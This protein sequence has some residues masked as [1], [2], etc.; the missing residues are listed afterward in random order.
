[1]AAPDVWVS[2]C[3]QLIKKRQRPAPRGLGRP[4]TGH[5][6]LEGKTH[7]GELWDA[8]LSSVAPAAAAEGRARG[9]GMRRMLRSRAAGNAGAGKAG[10]LQAGPFHIFLWVPRAA[11]PL[12]GPLSC[13]PPTP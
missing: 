8:C 12:L 10:K 4:Q 3:A 13:N 2:I 5:L 1:M 9:P 11:S 7:H 6:E